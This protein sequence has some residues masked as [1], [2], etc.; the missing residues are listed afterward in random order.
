MPA[1]DQDQRLERP[2]AA[3]TEANRAESQ[4]SL[5]AEALRKSIEVT[6]EG[7]ANG[8][9]STTQE[10][11]RRLRDAGA[12]GSVDSFMADFDRRA[13]QFL[14]ELQFEIAEIGG[15]PAKSQAAPDQG[16]QKMASA[17]TEFIA[18]SGQPDSYGETAAVSADADA[19]AKRAAE[20]YLSSAPPIP[21]GASDAAKFQEL[22][23][24]PPAGT[25][26]EQK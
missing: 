17:P 24:E 13:A 10:C 23:D 6:A 2:A 8:F 7:D 5:D 11:G 19:E 22:I 26:D 9:V 4:E 21:R 20:L 12:Y 1:L 18:V 16:R 15:E 25:P 14:T 3:E